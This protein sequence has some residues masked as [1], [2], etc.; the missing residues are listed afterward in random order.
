M[1]YAIRLDRVNHGRWAWSILATDFGPKGDGIER[2]VYDSTGYFPSCA[3]A[4]E[5]AHAVLDA[6]MTRA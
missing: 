4:A 5:D 3:A 2:T 1:T 6:E